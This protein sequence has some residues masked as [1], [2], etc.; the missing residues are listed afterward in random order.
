MFRQC[1]PEGLGGVMASG[2]H[3]TTRTSTC[4]RPL[5][6]HNTEW[7]SYNHSPYGKVKLSG[8]YNVD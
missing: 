5:A 7:V 8:A 3:E 4:S 2:D 6:F 1:S